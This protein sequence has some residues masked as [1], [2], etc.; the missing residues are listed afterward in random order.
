[1]AELALDT[2][3]AGEAGAKAF[4]DVGHR[5]GVGP[6]SV[7]RASATLRNPTAPS[8]HDASRCAL[9]RTAGKFTYATLPIAEVYQLGAALDYLERVGVARSEA[10][11]VGLAGRLQ[12]GLRAQ[13]FRLLTPP[14]NRAKR[15]SNRAR[16]ASW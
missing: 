9:P 4:D 5:Q 12:E 3:S 11:T 16:S 2:V 13:G 1:M 15:R 8:A 14:G 10:Q 7:Q 6:S